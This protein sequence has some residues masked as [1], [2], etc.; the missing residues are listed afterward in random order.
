MGFGWSHPFAS[1][2]ELSLHVK[3]HLKTH[4]LRVL[5]RC[6]LKDPLSVPR[7][8]ATEHPWHLADRELRNKE[9]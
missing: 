6:P 2:E 3:L 4:F 7:S 1:A 9:T 5:K 8:H